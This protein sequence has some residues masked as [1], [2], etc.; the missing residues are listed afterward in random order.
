MPEVLV[1]TSSDSAG[2]CHVDAYNPATGK[3]LWRFCTTEPQ[4]V[5]R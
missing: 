2:R 4:L 3:L 1:G 5:G